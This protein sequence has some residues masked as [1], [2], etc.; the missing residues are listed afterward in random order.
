MLSPAGHPV[1][2]VLLHGY[3]IL[4]DSLTYTWTRFQ[5]I[6]DM[7]ELPTNSKRELKNKKGKGNK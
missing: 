1:I 7:R 5:E 6:F 4:F 2:D 3:A